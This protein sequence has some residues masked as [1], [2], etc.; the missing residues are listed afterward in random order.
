MSYTLDNV[1]AECLSDRLNSKTAQRDTYLRDHEFYKSC[2]DSM[3]KWVESRL[4]NNKV[5]MLISFVEQ[6]NPESG[7]FV[8]CGGRKFRHFQLGFS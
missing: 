4:R 1:I 8:G 7:S 2:W 3:N 6:M 5:R